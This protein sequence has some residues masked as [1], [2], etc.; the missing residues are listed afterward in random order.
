MKKLLRGVGQAR[1]L[2]D[3]GTDKRYIPFATMKEITLGISAEDARQ[4]GG[5][6]LF[7]LDIFTHSKS[8]KIKITDAALN[9]EVFDLMGSTLETSENFLVWELLTVTSGAVATNAAYVV[10]TVSLETSDGV[11]ITTFTATTSPNITAIDNAYEG[12]KIIVRYETGDVTNVNSYS[13]KVNDEPIYFE[14]IHSSRY[15]DPADNKIKIFQTRIYRC[16]LVGNL[17][18]SFK[19]GEFSSP[20]IEAEVLDPGRSDY[21]VITYAF[22]DLPTDLVTS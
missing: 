22:G 5:D 15:R 19:E 17:D 1:I 4:T 14:V 16:R 12:Q 8:G 2:Y 6:R 7:P 10:G 11:G 21:K 9:M 18:Y 20:S 3:F 13:L